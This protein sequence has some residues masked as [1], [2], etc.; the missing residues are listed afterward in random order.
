MRTVVLGHRPPE[1]DQLIEKR[2]RCGQD[3]FDE[4]WSGDYHMAPGPSARH[5]RVDRELAV[6]LEPYAR[7]AGLVGTGPFNLGH[8]QDYRV[9]DGGFHRGRPTGKFLPTA[10]VVVEVLSPEDETFD[11]FAFY[12]ACGVE[13]ILVADPQAKGVRVWRLCDGAYVETARS[14]LLDLGTAEATV[15]VDW[16]E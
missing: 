15:G 7:R 6:L 3:R 10:A 14:S 11:K 1:L 12:A 16:P 2:R 5:G 9:P 8:P 4:V 13:E